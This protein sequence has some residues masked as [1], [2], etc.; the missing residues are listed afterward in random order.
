MKLH[1]SDDARRIAK[2]KLPW[3]VFDYIDYIDGAAGR[4]TGA[5]RNRAA[6]DAMTCAPAFYVMSASV[7]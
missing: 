2:R 6:F 1:S 7:I 3:M 4:E 5:A